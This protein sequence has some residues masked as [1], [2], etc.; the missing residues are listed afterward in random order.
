[1]TVNFFVTIYI[2]KYLG[3]NDFG[4]LNYGISF[5]GLFQ[6]IA[7]LGLNDIAV[8]NLV[9][10]ESAKHKILG[11][12]FVLKL[13]GA[14][15]AFFLV[16]ITAI[17]VNIDRE[18]FWL[19]I[20]IASGL[21]FTAFDVIDFWFRSQVNFTAIAIAKEIQ[22]LIFAIIKLCFV[23]WQLP[24]I[25]FVWLI[26]CDYLFKA[27]GKVVVYCRY[28]FSPKNW[29]LNFQEAKRLLADS[30][31]LIFSGIMIAIYMKIDQVMLGNMTS[32]ATLGHYAAAV[33]FI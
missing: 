29:Y 9:K 19:I 12:T 7:Y 6:T 1:M 25:A 13:I 33:K 24:L 8:R 11:T 2:V 30:Y 3:A 15:I 14:T 26:F 28:N 18:M 4:K 10:T 21:F 27:W 22:V 16:V 31:P 32:N 5:V 23:F 20:I 17:I